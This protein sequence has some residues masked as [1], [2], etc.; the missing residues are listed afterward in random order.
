ME[1]NRNKK[2]LR[3]VCAKCQFD[4]CLQKIAAT[5]I[6][7]CN[8]ICATLFYGKG[9]CAKVYAP[10]ARS[11]AS[12]FFISVETRYLLCLHKVTSNTRDDIYVVQK[13]CLKQKNVDF[14]RCVV[15]FMHDCILKVQ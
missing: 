14:I 6:G 5:G 8:Y 2:A 4:V 10:S 3:N 9:N 15:E 13:A 11:I 7:I 1:V 12:T